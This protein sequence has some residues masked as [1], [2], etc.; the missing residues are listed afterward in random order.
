MYQALKNQLKQKGWTRH[1]LAREAGICPS[2]VYAAMSGK[3]EMFPGWRRRIADALKV[4]EAEIFP[5][6]EG[7]NDNGTIKND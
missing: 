2:D 5:D 6:N 7:A 3:R 4:P 1:K